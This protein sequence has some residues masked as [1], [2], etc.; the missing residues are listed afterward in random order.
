MFFFSFKRILGI[1]FLGL[2]GLYAAFP[3]E[4][5]TAIDIALYGISIIH[6]MTG[7]VADAYAHTPHYQDVNGTAI[8][9]SGNIVPHDYETY[10]IITANA[11][12]VQYKGIYDHKRV[13]GS[14][15]HWHN[16]THS[17]VGIRTADAFVYPDGCSIASRTSGGLMLDTLYING[18]AAGCSSK[19]IDNTI[20]MYQRIGSLTLNYT[21]FVDINNDWRTLISVTNSHANPQ[22][23]TLQQ[24]IEVNERL[25]PMDISITQKMKR[26]TI[27][28]VP[29]E[30]V[31]LRYNMEDAEQHLSHVLA[32]PNATHTT[33]MYT[34]NDRLPAIVSRGTHVIDP[35]WTGTLVAASEYESF[36]SE[37]PPEC[38]P[39]ANA[40]SVDGT[41][42][43]NTL[44]GCGAYGI[45]WQNIVG[46]GQISYPDWITFEVIFDWSTTDTD[47]TPLVGMS[48]PTYASALARY[49]SST[50][51]RDFWFPPNERDLLNVG[52]TDQ[53]GWVN[54]R[55]NVTGQTSQCTY[56]TIHQVCSKYG[57]INT[58][59]VVSNV[60]G[61]V[62]SV[63]GGTS[64]KTNNYDLQTDAEKRHMRNLFHSVRDYPTVF[65]LPQSYQNDTIDKNRMYEIK[66]LNT[67]TTTKPHYIVTMGTNINVGAVS[68]INVTMH[69]ASSA[70]LDWSEAANATKY[71]VWRSEAGQTNPARVLNETT[72]TTFLVTDLTAGQSY[73]FAIQPYGGMPP[74]Y[75]SKYTTSAVVIRSG[76]ASIDGLQVAEGTLGTVLMSWDTAPNNLVYQIGRSEA[77]RQGITNVIVNTTATSHEV[78]G[79]NAGAIYYF[80][81]RSYGGVGNDISWGPWTVSPPYY[82]PQSVG[83]I[84]TISGTIQS[85]T[86]ATIA[87]TAAPN[88]IKYNIWRSGPDNSTIATELTNTTSLS[89]K[90]SNLHAH[91]YYSFGVRP[92]GGVPQQYGAWKNIT[93]F[94][95]HQIQDLSGLRA[96]IPDAATVVLSW[97]ESTGATGYT[98]NGTGGSVLKN[99]NVTTLGYTTTVPAGDYDIVWDVTPYGGSPARYVEG[100]SVTTDMGVWPVKPTGVTGRVLNDTALVLTWDR[101]AYV[102]KY[103]VT[104]EDSDSIPTDYANI[105]NNNFTVGGLQSGESYR[106]RVTAI[107]GYTG[108]LNVVSEWSGWFTMR[109]PITGVGKPNGLVLSNTPTT[110]AMYV[111]VG[112]NASCYNVSFINQDTQGIYKGVEK[113]GI[114]PGLHTDVSIGGLTK[115]TTYQISVYNWNSTDWWVP[116]ERRDISTLLRTGSYDYDNVTL[117][118]EL[119][120]SGILSIDWPVSARTK[121]DAVWDAQRSID[122]GPYNYTLNGTVTTS[123]S[124]VLPYR[125]VGTNEGLGE[126]Q[127]MTWRFMYENAEGQS[128]WAYSDPVMFEDVPEPPY[129]L[130]VYAKEAHWV[131]DWEPGL[132][133]AI[134]GI[135]GYQFQYKN[136]D[137][138][139]ITATNDT[140]SD[141]SHGRIDHYN[142]VNLDV[143]IKAYNDQGSSEYSAIITGKG[144]AF[145]VFTLDDLDLDESTDRATNPNWNPMTVTSTYVPY[146]PPDDHDDDEGGHGH[147]DGGARGQSEGGAVGAGHPDD[148]A[149]HCPKFADRIRIDVEIKDFDVGD[150]PTYCTPYLPDGTALHPIRFNSTEHGHGNN[151]HISFHMCEENADGEYGGVH[152]L[153][154]VRVECYNGEGANRMSAST[155][156]ALD[157]ALTPAI[158]WIGDFF[159]TANPIFGKDGANVGGLPVVAVL[160]LMLA[161]IG[162]NRVNEFAGIL[163]AFI[164][165]G[166]ATYFGI[167]QD[168]GMWTGV[169]ILILVISLA[170]VKRRDYYE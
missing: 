109:T 136:D 65:F 151:T 23:W 58:C 53:I 110:V 119:S 83:V 117:T 7:F 169:G 113:C 116:G 74:E 40:Q 42:V 76:G 130:K 147:D 46:S 5:N 90:E 70:T 134:D 139:W 62:E 87:W 125:L 93:M 170:L 157:P 60:Y 168:L 28:S 52:S 150:E 103:V 133:C 154:G 123:Q 17:G 12:H 163:V 29:V 92:Y 37:N 45:H 59:S 79:L 27:T 44:S 84:P 104:V 111:F 75:G 158:R 32:V 143:R 31:D 88:A 155:T 80:G 102:N 165:L 69:S 56:N 149:D 38:D 16:Y 127:A 22:A 144:T 64:C 115:D 48:F 108:E 124:N 3:D 49:D 35:S 166:I 98:V 148:E 160:I 63:Y 106:Y 138:V 25:P 156:I 2:I 50:D 1:G 15:N 82:V 126:C 101:T 129:D 43:Q 94:V 9:A 112:T 120:G 71:R 73:V 97:D 86:E 67:A 13:L 89:F 8:D 68:S 152:G 19:R 122:Y 66:R 6:D 159:G 54:T 72:S 132:A 141:I 78:A 81:V 85:Y 162:F 30:Y 99:E 118:T 137:G 4:F 18:K 34:Y 135:I 145:S 57:S 121:H 114:S 100:Q 55:G 33:I 21:Y 164:I 47:T 95:G 11:T 26:D 167:L 96:T 153:Q 61:N 41:V 20:Q 36:E 140:G 128:G 146:P 51:F 107:G 14:D 161:C 77:N 142:K 24:K 105:I 131:L 39:D 91:S 10:S